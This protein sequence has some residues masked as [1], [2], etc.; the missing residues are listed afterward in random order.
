MLLILTIV[1]TVAAIAFAW[2][3]WRLR[4]EERRRSDA[5]VAALSSVLDERND[6]LLRYESA[7]AAGANELFAPQHSAAA[8]GAPVIKLAAAV[9]MGVTLLIV[10]AMNNRGADEVPVGQSAS[11]QGSAPLELVS[12]RHERE[13]DTL[14]VTGLVR[15]PRNGGRLTRVTA[16]VLTFNRAGA[17][18]GTGNAGLDFVTLEPGD[19]SPFVVTVRGVTDVGRYRVS[20]R[21][22]GG[23]VRHVDRRADQLRLASTSAGS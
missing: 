13:G 10:V 9:V 6:P 22:D 15:N 7:A 5:R 1:S 17:F 2:T 4:R 3:A 23:G 14:K 20:F 8:A 21:T 18:V 11:A 16:V 12:M 19:E